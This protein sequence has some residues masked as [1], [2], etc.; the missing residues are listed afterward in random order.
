MEHIVSGPTGIIHLIVS[1]V[2]M[3]SGLF[4]LIATK[5]TKIHKRIG[6]V[7]SVSMLL[8]N[9]TAFL[10]YRLYGKFGIFHWFAIV[11]CLT[12]LAGLSPV[13]IKKGKNYVLTHLNFMYWSVVGLYCAFMAEIFSRL[14]KIIL[15]EN[16][17]PMNAFYKGVGIGV[18]TVIVI[19]VM[20]FLKYRPKWIQ[21][22]E[23]K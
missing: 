17:E 14:P 19:G 2:A 1:I 10:I 13:L 21:Q 15:T 18:G 23:R 12:L 11:S 7:Y 3:L 5:G 22:H 20:F 6:Y 9:L 16:G 8:V 4:V